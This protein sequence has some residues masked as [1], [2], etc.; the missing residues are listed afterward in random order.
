VFVSRER[1]ELRVLLSILFSPPPLSPFYSYYCYY[2]IL[3]YLTAF[4]IPIP[5]PISCS[6]DLG[7]RLCLV[8][9]ILQFQ[10]NSI[11]KTLQ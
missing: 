7:V 6:L 10:F 9:S 4:F 1:L 8:T 3:L 5:I 11:H 2:S